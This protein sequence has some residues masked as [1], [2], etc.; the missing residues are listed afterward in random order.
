MAKIEKNDKTSS[1]QAGKAFKKRY[2]D[3]KNNKDDKEALMPNLHL[4][5]LTVDPLRPMEGA[6]ELAEKVKNDLALAGTSNE[7]N[8]NQ[9]RGAEMGNLLGDG[10]P[11]YETTGEEHPIDEVENQIEAQN[12]RSK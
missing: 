12:P 8:Q 1:T 10:V 11:G 6:A 2:K 3:N 9:F 4:D 5:K 7:L